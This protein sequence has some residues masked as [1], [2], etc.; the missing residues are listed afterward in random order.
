MYLSEAI[1]SNTLI[2]HHNLN[3]NYYNINFHSAM[4]FIVMLIKHYKVT[5]L[6]VSM[7]Y[8]SA[9]LS[10]VTLHVLIISYK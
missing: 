8:M 5:L 6:I 4:L 3:N 9:K 2:K 10:I 1:Y 7:N